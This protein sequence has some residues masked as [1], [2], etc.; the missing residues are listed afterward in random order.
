MQF[1]L[2][3]VLEM[4]ESLS[5]IISQPLPIKV[6]FKM[7]K[8]IKAIDEELEIYNNKNN[9]LIRKYGEE[10]EDGKI[11]VSDDNR[12]SYFKEYKELLDVDIEI[13]LDPISVNDL[14]DNLAIKP[15]DLYKL[16]GKI[17]IE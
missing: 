7:S 10:T 15:I 12:E 5:N 8:I 4:K 2:L 16:S 1:K 3:E 9:D 17:I 14:G 11:K 6:S 13:Q